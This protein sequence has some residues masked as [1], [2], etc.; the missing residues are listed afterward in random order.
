MQAN[1][2]WRQSGNIEISII[3][4]IYRCKIHTPNCV[5]FMFLLSSGQFLQK[6]HSVHLRYRDSDLRMMLLITCIRSNWTRKEVE[7]EDATTWMKQKINYSE[8][9]PNSF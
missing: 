2:K 1:A 4:R 8:G 5:C 3:Y 7:K 9:A 6:I